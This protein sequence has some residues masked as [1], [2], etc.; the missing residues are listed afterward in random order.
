MTN[1]KLLV[2]AAAAVAITAAACSSDELTSVNQNPNSPTDAPSTAL[3]V[4]ATRNAV[5]RWLDGVG[6]TRYAFL[7]QHMAEVQYPE[8]DQYV[9][10][11]A[12]STSVLLFDQSYSIEL[13]DFELVIRRG[14]AAS[15]PGLWGPA[16]VM[17]SWEF[18]ILT[19][20]FGDVPYSQAFKADSGILQPAFDTQQSI[21]TDLFTKLGEA[22]TAMTATSATNVLGSS[23]QIYGGSP[24]LWARFANSLRLRHALRLVNVASATTGTQLTAALTAPGGVIETN[25]Q[26]AKL[27]WPGDGVYDNPWATN[28]KGRDDHRISTRLLTYLRDYNDPRLPVYA[29]RADDDMVEDPDRM[30]KYCPDATV[31][32]YVGL[33]NALDHPEASPLVA[34][35]SR[36]GEIFYPG[37]TSYGTFGGS[38][39]SFPSFLM[40]AAEVDFIRA[41]AAE[42]S[43]GGLT[44]AQ[45]AGFYNSAITKSMEMWGITGTA[46]TTYLA[47]PGVSYLAAATTEERQKRIAIQKWL[48]LLI[49]PIQAW[50]E[51]RRT[52]QPAILHPGPQAETDTIPRRLQYSTTDVAVNAINYKAAVAR[53]G[54]DDLE[55]RIYWD[56]APRSAPTYEDGCGAR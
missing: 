7:S 54:S 56:K 16:T 13:Q 41:E 35:T 49:D 32:C 55:T 22:A 28:F 12:P 9:R 30:L 24:A 20:V 29:M 5:D 47:Q 44:P 25:A 45:A 6:G 2:A 40:T 14:R 36:I 37:V 34:F 42:R 51:F 4:N 46:V 50:A 38:G 1:R 21:Y 31:P 19:D 15:Q 39:A 26:N 11:L 17:K 53:Q 52:C 10:L 33:E 23:D 43:L 8:S 18:G 27:T 3:F 48:A